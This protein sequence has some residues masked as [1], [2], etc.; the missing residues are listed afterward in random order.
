MATSTNYNY[1]FSPVQ[2]YNFSFPLVQH[3]NSSP[4]PPVQPAL[5]AIAE[6]GMY[7][8][9][10]IILL[11]YAHKKRYAG[12]KNIL[13][14]KC[15]GKGERIDL[16]GTTETHVLTTITQCHSTLVMNY[17]AVMI[18]LILS[19]LCVIIGRHVFTMLIPG[20]FLISYAQHY[21]CFILSYALHFPCLFLAY[22]ICSPCLLLA[23]VAWIFTI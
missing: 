9:C 18:F 15:D 5:R 10:L 4:F 20:C 16:I 21:T 1:P 11:A 19:F 8:S 17:I 12:S 6:H 13:T 22:T 23:V 7:K 3:Y 2:H 14:L